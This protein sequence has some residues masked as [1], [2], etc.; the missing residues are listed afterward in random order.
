MI[1]EILRQTFAAVE[2]FLQLGVGDVAGDDHRAGQ[3]D[4]GADGILGKDPADLFHRLI[5]VDADHVAGQLAVVDFRQ[6]VGRIM[7]QSFQIDAVAGDL[8]LDLAVGGAGNA[9]AHRTGGAMAGQADDPQVVAE[10][11]AA[12]LGAD[13]HTTGHFQN[14]GFHFQVPEGMTV[15]AA[16]RRQ[17]VEIFGRGQFHRLQVHLGR[18]AADGDG[19]VIGRAGRGSQGA[20]LR[21]EELDQGLRVQQGLGLLVL[22]GLVG[23]A[24]AFGHEQELVGVAAGG[25]EVDLRRQIVAGVDLFV[26]VQRRDLAV[27]QVHLAIGPRDALGQRRFVAAAGPHPLAL[28]AHDDGGA[29]ILAHGKHHTGGDI[30]VHQQVKGDETIVFRS[31]RVIDDGPQLFQMGRAQ[32]VRYLAEGLGRQNLQGGRIDQNHGGAFEIG[33]RDMVRG[34]FGVGSVVAAKGE[35]VGEHSCI[36][37]HGCP[38]VGR[39]DGW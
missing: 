30:G 15:L 9:D 6:I 32:Q 3:S 13:A 11:F 21:V 10:I 5:E 38:E 18:G 16:G 39:F 37:G 8:A 4:A 34:E 29:R 20:D 35:N 27:A 22:I 19:Q 31:F 23:R 12:E 26:H 7:F 36:S 24:A 33:D 25:V 17:M 2:A 28:F 14:R 1:F